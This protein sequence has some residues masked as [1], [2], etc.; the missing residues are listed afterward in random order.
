MAA[1]DAR[2]LPRKNT[3]FRVTF[4]IYNSSGDLVTGASGL[5]SEVS[6]DGGTFA[7]CT[8]EAT[9]IATSSGVYY[10]DLSAGEMNGDTIAINV[11]S[12][13]NKTTT[14]VIYPEELGDVRVDVGQISGDATAADNAESFFDGT[15]YPGTNNV[16]PTTTTVTNGVTIADGAITA[17]K[18]ATDAL[19]AAKLAADAV[20]EIQNGLATAASIVALNN[21][22]A[23]QVNA[24]VDAALADVGLTTTVTG[25]VD[26]AVSTRATQAQVATEL[27]AYDAP[28]K[29]ELDAAVALL[30]TASALSTA[31]SAILSAIDA[32][33][34]SAEIDE[35][36]SSNHGEGSWQAGG[37]G[38]PS[39]TEFTYTVTSN[40][41]G[42]PIPDVSVWCST[43]NLFSSFVWFGITDA[44][45]VARDANGNKPR[46]TP[47]TYYF[48]LRKTGY[49]FA[50][51][52]E[53][54]DE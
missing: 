31:S 7:D 5:D 17:A 12:T 30:A 43:S 25:R 49:T 34:T 11:K 18:I 4:P 32:V 22:S 35:E 10:L 48:L 23:A 15:G 53:T 51:D 50:V 45:G 20:S 28:T 24:E 14:I 9:E 40:P 6:I 36:L 41:G 44:F 16:I 54:I 8:N 39:G 37:G 42:A 21:L 33:P 52:T 46:L 26:A 27:A 1:S 19:T 2:P 29:A 38:V 47:G 13:S 3:A